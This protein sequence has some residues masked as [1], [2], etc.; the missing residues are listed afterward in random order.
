[1]QLVLVPEDIFIAFGMF[2]SF[3]DVFS[4]RLCGS[5]HLYELS[6]SRTF[7][8][9]WIHENI[10]RVGLWSPERFLGLL[11]LPQTELERLALRTV[12]I[13][14]DQHKLPTLHPKR[15]TRIRYDGGIISW[16]TLH[17]GRWAFLASSG[18]HLE[19][20][21]I[22]ALHRYNVALDLKGGWVYSGLVHATKDVDKHLLVLSSSLQKSY[23]VQCVLDKNP[24]FIPL[25]IYEGLSKPLAAS[26]NL[27]L[28][29]DS[30]TPQTAVLAS[31]EGVMCSLSLL[32]HDTAPQLAQ[33][34][35]FCES[36]VFIF[37]SSAVCVYEHD[38][39]S[40]PS[41]YVAPNLC[42]NPKHII[43]LKS[44]LF[45][46]QP[47]VGENLNHP[48]IH[49][50]ARDEGE[51]FLLLQLKAHEDTGLMTLSRPT[52][53]VPIRSV[54]LACRNLAMTSS[55]KA[56]VF[57]TEDERHQTSTIVSC[58][59]EGD[60]IGRPRILWQL[61]SSINWSA[62]VHLLAFDDVIGMMAVGTVEPGQG[63]MWLVDFG[64]GFSVFH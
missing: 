38:M 63:N 15:L 11:G 53:E 22:L 35:V 26:G 59:L 20:W 3:G 8:S 52:E 29:A 37:K 16:V 42:I 48:T 7:W 62:G 14:H 1:M 46:I 33:S 19:L 34:A 17:A 10:V 50:V 9:A 41:V 2:L 25:R 56:C 18:G 43:E 45:Q 55:C 36:N 30:T 21:D 61:P 57:S 27:V 49:L 39:I 51:N 23:L 6:L 40:D 58:M 31:S 28:F 24:A 54:P 5:K 32:V 12:C 4:L 13:W 44:R 47:W 64:G 60:R